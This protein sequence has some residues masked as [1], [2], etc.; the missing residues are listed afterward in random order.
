M[1]QWEVIS[2]HTWLRYDEGIGMSINDCSMSDHEYHL[3][4]IPQEL[5]AM[6]RR[7]AEMEGKP[8]PQVAV[9]A[10]ARGAGIELVGSS[11]FDD[12]AGSWVSDPVCE[13]ALDA[14]REHIDPEPWP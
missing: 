12:L 9:E 4:G 3:A 5:D 7:R 14:M 10:M 1:I 2:A 11:A 8:L 6:L 13:Q